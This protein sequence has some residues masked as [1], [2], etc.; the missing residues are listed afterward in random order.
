MKRGRL[1]LVPFPFT[2][3]SHHKVRPAVVVSSEKLKGPDVV[4][5]FISSVVDERRLLA[6]DYVVRR[7]TPLFASTGLRVDSVFRMGKLATVDRGIILGEIGHVPAELQS[8]LDRKLRIALALNQ[9][10]HFGRLESP[11]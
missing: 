7:G 3:L 9:V 10:S 4:V 11:D 2:D 5:A 1:V 6:C 8:L